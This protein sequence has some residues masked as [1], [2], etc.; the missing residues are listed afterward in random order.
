MANQLKAGVLLSYGNILA[1]MVVG[2]VYTPVM[3]RLLG[4]SEYGLYSLIGALVGYLSILDLGLGN[5]IVRYTA[6]NRAV[7][8]R[9]REAELNGLFLFIYSLIG[10]VTVGIGMLLYT[11]LDTLFGATLSAEEMGKARIMMVL[12]IFNFAFTF[13]LSIFGSI[14]QAYER[15]I[16]LRVVNILRVLLNPCI[17]LS[18][19]LMGYGSVMMVVVSTVLNLVC[20]MTTVWYCFRHLHVR[21]CRGTYEKTFLLEIGAYSFFIFLN[22]IMDKIYWGTGQFVLG[23]VSGTVE[24]AIYAVVMQFLMMYMQFSTAISGV[25]LPKVTMLVAEG[26]DRVRLTELL[27]KIGRLQY[28]V[29]GGILSLFILTGR[30]FLYL[31]A[32]EEYL[33]AY[34]MILLLML[35]L[36]IPLVQNAGIAILQAMNRNRYR[37]TVYTIAA[38]LNLVVSVPLAMKYGGMGCAVATAVALFLS[39]GYIMNRYYQQSIGLG[40]GRFWKSIARIA[41]GSILLLSVGLA[42][43]QT[44]PI[45]YGWHTF[46]AIAGGYSI[47]YLL[48]L[49]YTGMNEYEKGLCKKVV[50]RLTGGYVCRL[51]R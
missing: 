6:R 31:W 4:Q 11:N 17:V 51:S 8:N 20:L 44:Y 36:F 47:L 49:F 29:I 26:A 7:G 48:V 43:L 19:L 1:S 18:L 5:T 9:Q 16:Y 27:I 28:I 13:P 21:F 30:E 23:V 14:M 40:I 45:T 38:V 46:L 3:L 41:G 25:L 42:V 33:S 50:A 32:G 12:L 39:T 24:V 15:F 34:P 22:A 2:L 35:S 37:M 10:L